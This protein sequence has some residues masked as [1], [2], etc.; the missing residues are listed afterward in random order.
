MIYSFG[1]P[2]IMR[3]LRDLSGYFNSVG[4]RAVL[5]DTGMAYVNLAK[6]DAPISRN[7]GSTGLV[8]GGAL[9]ASIYHTVNNFGTLDV[10]VTIKAGGPMA[11]YAPHVEFGTAPSMRIPINKQVMFWMEDSAGRKVQV[12]WHLMG[13]QAGLSAKGYMAKFRQIVWH[14]GTRAQPFFFKQVP[15]ILPRL[16]NALST[17]IRQ[18]WNRL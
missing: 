5:E 4:F 3:K 8:A 2:E 15:I 1:T 17:S 6:A 7:P 16:M 14:P 9:R 11:P 13:G 18:Q 10:N 12:P